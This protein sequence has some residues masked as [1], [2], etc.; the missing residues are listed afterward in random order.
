MGEAAVEAI[1]PAASTVTAVVEVAVV[2][3]AVG[4]PHAASGAA[5][6]APCTVALHVAATKP[7]GEAV[8]LP[9]DPL[10]GPPSRWVVRVVVHGAGGCI[11]GLGVGRRDWLVPLGSLCFQP[12]ET[13]VMRVH[14]V[15]DGSHLRRLPRSVMLA[16]SLIKKSSFSEAFMA[17]GSETELAMARRCS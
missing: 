16:I 3:A 13:A 8:S 6:K 2:N 4:T 17:A 9:I 1:P 12:C 5:I 14:P 15:G 7:V 10:D 11:G